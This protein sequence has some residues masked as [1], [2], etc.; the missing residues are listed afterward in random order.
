MIIVM[1]LKATQEN[2]E[3]VKEKLKLFGFAGCCLDVENGRKVLRAPSSA[4]I[5]K[6][7]EEEIESTPGV[8]KVILPLP[9]VPDWWS[10]L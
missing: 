9:I 7:V 1:G 4:R 10:G 8:E 3:E 6:E 2:V 5:L